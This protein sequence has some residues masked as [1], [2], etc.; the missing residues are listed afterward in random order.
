LKHDSAA[1]QQ[2]LRLA[3]QKAMSDAN[4]IA[5]GLN[6]HTGAVLSATEGTNV[7][8]VAR[9]AVSAAI[10]QTPI[11]PNDVSIQA[12]VTVDVQIAQ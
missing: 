6:V 3:A 11:Q 9:F 4:A 2:A 1:R 8:P 12:T 5:S 10:T 7:T